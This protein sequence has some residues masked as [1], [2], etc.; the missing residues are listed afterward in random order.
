MSHSKLLYTTP[1][2]MLQVLKWNIVFEGKT[3]QEHVS[4]QKGKT[5]FQ[6]ISIQCYFSKIR[7]TLETKVFGDGLFLP[8]HEG[9][10]HC[11]KTTLLNTEL[12]TE[13]LSVDSSGKTLTTPTIPKN[14]ENTRIIPDSSE[15]RVP[16]PR[17]SENCFF[18]NILPLV[19]SIFWRVWLAFWG[20]ASKYDVFLGDLD[21][22]VKKNIKNIKH[23]RAK[24]CMLVGGLPTVD[25]L[26]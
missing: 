10:P 23:Q 17:L 20:T 5:W 12:F 8:F 16:P 2:R 11:Q 6:Y 13:K 18:F 14:L 1:P 15:S 9:I 21:E 24:K 19:F 22:R 3:T 25:F 7:K 4:F 26:P